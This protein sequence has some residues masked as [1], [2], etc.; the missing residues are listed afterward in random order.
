LT[1]IRISSLQEDSER[2]I[3]LFRRKKYDIDQFE[4][5]MKPIE[6]EIKE[7]EE[8]YEILTADK[9]EKLNQLVEIQTVD[10]IEKFLHMS[11]GERK[12]LYIKNFEYIT[13]TDAILRVKA[14]TGWEAQF[15]MRNLPIHWQN[16]IKLMSEDMTDWKRSTMEKIR[17]R[18]FGNNT[19]EA[20][21]LRNQVDFVR[22]YGLMAYTGSTEN[23]VYPSIGQLSFVR[24]F[25]LRGSTFRSTDVNKFHFAFI[26][27]K[28]G[29]TPPPQ[30]IKIKPVHDG[31]DAS[32]VW[33]YKRDKDGKNSFFNKVEERAEHHGLKDN[34]DKD[35][36]K[37]EILD[38]YRNEESTV[39][40]T[41]A[42]LL[43]MGLIKK[44]KTETPLEEG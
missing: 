34:L 9:T 42:E 38:N 37:V 21:K 22:D 12:K 28:D 39:E 26:H 35:F 32:Y 1:A 25:A 8:R 3:H 2:V 13:L 20:D 15:N 31:C 33:P 19:V 17:S 30:F 23:V 10:H 4:A 14:V 6:N 41:I 27:L 16:K 18:V 43:L 36:Q 40:A 44:G 29:V 7:L 5:E 24:D 11:E